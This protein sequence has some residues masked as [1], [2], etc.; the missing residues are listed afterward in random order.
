M[1]TPLDKKKSRKSFENRKNETSILKR[2][3]ATNRTAANGCSMTEQKQDSIVRCKEE[4]P[5]KNL[6][7]TVCS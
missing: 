2:E 6:L 5:T 7:G 1:F 4:Q 3:N